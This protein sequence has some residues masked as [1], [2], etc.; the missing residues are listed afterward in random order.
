MVHD[1]KRV[2]WS[3]T[4][5][6]AGWSSPVARQAHN[7]KVVGSNP[8]PATTNFLNQTSVRDLRES[9]SRL[10]AGHAHMARDGGRIGVYPEIM[11][12]RF[13]KHHL[14]EPAVKIRQIA[15]A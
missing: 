1:P 12:S 4:N 7:L 15:R 8:T 13:S 5:G 6:N 3:Q 14:I 11:P 9:Q 10:A 2:A